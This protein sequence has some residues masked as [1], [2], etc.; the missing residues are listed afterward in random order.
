MYKELQF[1]NWK[2][3]RL[4]EL[5]IDDLQDLLNEFDKSTK[6]YDS[7]GKIIR[8]ITHDIILINRYEFTKSDILK[9]IKD[10]KQ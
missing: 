4:K 1:P 6:I 3:I 5:N 8:T 7:Y 10:R 9:E 2:Q